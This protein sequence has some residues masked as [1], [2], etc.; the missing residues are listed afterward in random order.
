[1][2]K[3][4]IQSDKIRDR[5]YI[6]KFYNPEIVT[7]LDALAATHTCVRIQELIDNGTVLA[8]TGDEI[9]KAAYG[10]GDIPFVRT[11]DIQNWEIKAAPKQGVS[12]EIYDEYAAAQDV[13]EGDILLVRDGTYLIGVNCFVTRFDK[14]VLYQS[15]LLKLRVNDPTAVDPTLLFL[16]LNCD[17]VQRQM[18]SF[19]FTADI[20]DTIGRRFFDTI[21]PLPNDARA[22]RSLST[23]TQAALRARMRGKAF[24]K[25]CP[26]LMEA[27]LRTGSTQLL[28]AF[29]AASDD[30]VYDL[31]TQETISSEFGGFEYFWL[32]SDEVRELI[33]I[34]K[35]YEPSIREELSSV[36]GECDLRSFG[37][38]R[39]AGVLGYHTGDEIGK[40]AYGT[41]VIP[42]LRT[43]D[44]SN[45]EVSH[46]PKQGVSAD[47]YRQYA[48]RQ[49]VRE[50]DVLLVR[51]GTYLVG[52]SCIIT[53]EDVRSLYCGGL[54]KIRAQQQNELDPFLLLGL[55]NSYVVKRQIRTKQ[56]TRDVIDTLGNRLDEVLLPV[57]KA[58]AVRRAIGDAVRAVITSRI[59]AR[60]E[61]SALAAEFDR[62]FGT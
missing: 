33:L 60:H 50:N 5:V 54:V 37:E 22:R 59:S 19:Q 18:R 45:W 39:D 56:F 52:T 51:D 32:Y 38:L 14:E 21:I 26:T 3:F 16:A 42:F 61:I 28:G 58:P 55:L 31:L 35:Y 40:M 27:V 53:A 13:R 36:A 12:Q 20:I 11:S 7:R 30:E 47:I 25:H 24:I 29:A 6:P 34:P 49:D 46:E 44:F 9:G 23:R 15:H 4:W 41:G 2:I 10:T 43:S 1:M 48:A 57:P 8:A 62:G 17:V